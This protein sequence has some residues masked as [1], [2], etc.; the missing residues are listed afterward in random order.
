[1]IR[2]RRTRSA[3]IRNLAAVGPAAAIAAAA[4]L[5]IPTTALAANP[6]ACDPAVFPR[7]FLA[8]ES[9]YARNTR[10]VQMRER[11]N[12]TAPSDQGDPEYP[13]PL[14]VDL[15]KSPSYTRTIH[16]YP[17]DQVAVKFKRHE[18]AAVTAT[19]V[20]VHTVYDAL[21]NGSNVRCTRVLRTHYKAPPGP[22]SRHY[23]R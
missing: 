9:V 14:R 4:A 6:P 3:S 10:W 11:E 8:F 23:H 20:E 5:G 17:K 1:M 2:T 22:N 12:L 19:Y 15:S 18:T 21:G 7:P 13:F 16:S